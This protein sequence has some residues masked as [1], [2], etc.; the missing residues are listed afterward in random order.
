MIK[1]TSI[2]ILL[3]ICCSVFANDSVMVKGSES[4]TI[5]YDEKNISIEREELN[6][7]FYKDFY[8]VTVKYEYE[9][10]GSEKTLQLGFPIKYA[11]TAGAEEKDKYLNQFV[12]AQIFNDKKIQINKK[13][14]EVKK[15]E[16]YSIEGIYWIIREVGFLKGK[17]V[18][19]IE[20]TGPYSRAGFFTRFDYIIETA[21]CWNN[22]IK[23]LKI[24]IHNDNAVLLNGR[25]WHIGHYNEDNFPD[26][27]KISDNTFHFTFSN[28]DP[29]KFRDI[30]FILEDYEFTKQ[31]HFE[32][33]ASGWCY[34]LYHI[35]DNKDEVWLYTKDQ[36][37]LFLNCFYAS[38]GY[39]FKNQK[40]QSYFKDMYFDNVSG[41]YSIYTPDP[42]FNENK[43]ND[44]EKENIQFLI[45]LKKRLYE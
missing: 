41:N 45:N 26:N 13:Y 21:S 19:R 17:N 36:I 15:D 1:Y 5:N 44:I 6:I 29:Q 28:V 12:F 9:N 8:K 11:S 35:Y 25:A 34:A 43:F 40:L 10:N 31:R 38:K 2:I 30:S 24:N 18:S 7:Y 27:V 42:N 23:D 39:I 4:V 22:N 16:S 32:D 14:N 20:F 3:F 37:Q 33:W